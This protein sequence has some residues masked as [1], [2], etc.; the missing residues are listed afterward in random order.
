MWQAGGR[1]PGQPNWQAGRGH[2]EQRRAVRY[3]HG[4]G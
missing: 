1:G 3:I 4:N 2:Y